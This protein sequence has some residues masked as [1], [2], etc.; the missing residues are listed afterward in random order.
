M[1]NKQSCFNIYYLNFSK[2]YEISMMINNVVV[3]AIQREKSSSFE[4]FSSKKSSVSANMGIDS[5]MYLASIKSVIGA[6]TSERNTNSSKMI[7]SLDV[8]TT[9]SILL[10]QIVEKCAV[11]ESLNSKELAT[12]SANEGD[13]IKIDNIKLKILNEENLR[14][15]LMLRKDALKGFRVEGMEINNLVSSILQDYSYVLFGQLPS[16]EE[17]LIKIP[18]ETENEFENKYKVDDLL[19]GHVS[20]VGV[21]KGVVT[22]SFITSNTFNYMVAMGGS[23]QIEPEKKVF[24]SSIPQTPIAISPFIINAEDDK[25]YSFIDVIAIVQDV[26]FYSPPVGEI[27][28]KIPWYKRLLD[29]FMGG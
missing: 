21:Y 1:V 27:T 19:I 6:E 20:I 13:L 12:S 3:S 2:V 25:R 22:E 9:K 23:P 5:Q 15:I 29:R 7:E 18:M 4:R 10:R 8:K 16:D 14:Q 24:P 11:R 28:V 17:I 26:T